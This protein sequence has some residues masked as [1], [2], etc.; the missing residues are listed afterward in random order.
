MNF[1]ETKLL[2]IFGEILLHAHGYSEQQNW[3]LESFYILIIFIL[4]HI[5]IIYYCYYKHCYRERDKIVE[6]ILR[7]PI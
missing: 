6:S 5:I 3:V 7:K 4:L 1:L 2:I